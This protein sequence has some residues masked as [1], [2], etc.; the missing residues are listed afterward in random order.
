M[1]DDN[2][3]EDAFERDP[4]AGKPLYN[5]CTICTQVMP[6]ECFEENDT[7]IVSSICNSCLTR[8]K[9]NARIITRFVEWS[10]TCQKYL[11]ARGSL[12][13][14]LMSNYSAPSIERAVLTS[15]VNKE[16]RKDLIKTLI[17]IMGDTGDQLF[18][19]E[20]IEELNQFQEK[21]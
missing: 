2:S 3:L 4:F 17:G 14:L 10:K 15:I 6:R 5:T 7:E 16:S 9:V 12:G 8:W 18:L 21:Q 20:C 19:T 13:A 11:Y 1:S